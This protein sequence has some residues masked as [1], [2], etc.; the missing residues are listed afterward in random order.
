MILQNFISICFVVYEKNDI[1]IVKV[2]KV[3]FA[4]GAHLE[5]ADF[6]TNL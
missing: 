5:N 6:N 2:V 4:N 1:L 3:T